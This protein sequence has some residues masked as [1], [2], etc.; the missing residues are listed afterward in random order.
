MTEIELND[1]ESE[2]EQKKFKSKLLTSSNPVSS[3]FYS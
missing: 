2:S 3:V 1:I